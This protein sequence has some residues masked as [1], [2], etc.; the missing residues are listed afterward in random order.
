MI[1]APDVWPLVKLRLGLENDTHKS[2]AELYIEEL[3]QRIRH[4]INQQRIP[5]GLLHTWA[6]MASAALSAE[7]GQILF[8]LPEQVKAQ[9]VSIG[10]TSVKT[11]LVTPVAPPRPTVAV[12]DQVVFDYRIDLNHYRKL[13]W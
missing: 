5:D 6:A 11:S 2:L 9:E 1:T 10:D 4:D 8:P 3:G 13:R 12:M 7:Q